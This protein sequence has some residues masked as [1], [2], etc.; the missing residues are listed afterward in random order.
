MTIT[1]QPA[2]IAPRLAAVA[3]GIALLGACSSSDSAGV[4]TTTTVESTT[5]VAPST[6]VESTTTVDG[7]VAAATGSYTIVA[8]DTLIGIAERAGVSVDDLVAANGWTD[9]TDHAIFPG[10][11]I[12]LPAG[13]STPAPATSAGAASTTTAAAGSTP[14][15]ESAA[16]DCAGEALL[17]ALGDP[18]FVSFDEI[19]CADGWAG[20][21]Y[22][23]DGN[24]FKSAIF[25]AEGG[26][27][28]LQDY[29][30]VCD[31][32]PDISPAAQ[33]YCPGG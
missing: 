25:R 20:V 16:L 10:D 14:L 30:T 29:A 8:G 27:W 17:D 13:A 21:G 22:F 19:S 32:F 2:G 33:V 26:R 15:D 6:T 18:D 12:T 31:E 28:V 9:G 5:T 24:A 11:V 23:V 1:D 7:G 3:I 4:D